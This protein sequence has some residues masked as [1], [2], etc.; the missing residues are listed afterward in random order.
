MWPDL[1]PLGPAVRI[2]HVGADGEMRQTFLLGE[3]IEQFRDHLDHQNQITLEDIQEMM[4]MN[5]EQFSEFLEFLKEQEERQEQRHAAVLTALAHGHGGRNAP[6]STPG[7]GEQ[8]SPEPAPS[9]FTQIKQQFATIAA[10]VAAAAIVAGV[11]VFQFHGVNTRIDDANTSIN[12]RI[13]D[14]STSTDKRFDDLEHRF[15]DVQSDIKDVRAD[16]RMTFIS[17]GSHS[18]TPPTTK[19]GSPTP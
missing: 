16:I 17:P 5:P 8:P 19:G 7:N 15:N 18:S 12:K 4:S 10:V 2:R 6:P 9:F 3:A 11:G 14:A 13:D 1:E